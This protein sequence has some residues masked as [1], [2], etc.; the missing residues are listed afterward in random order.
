MIP[1]TRQCLPPAASLISRECLALVADTSL[2]GARVVRELNA[3]I[4]VRG[5]PAMI[6]SDNGTEFTSRAIL[7]WQLE[8]GIA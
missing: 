8:A 7:G 3:I 6:V 1:G 2:S 4:A 5:R